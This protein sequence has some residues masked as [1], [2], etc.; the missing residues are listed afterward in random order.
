MHSD[1]SATLHNVSTPRA[2]ARALCRNGCEEL[3]V[4]ATVG[5]HDEKIGAFQ[6]AAGLIADRRAGI[7]S[8]RVFGLRD[9]SQKSMEV[10]GG[11]FG[12][13][14]WPL[15]WLDEGWQNDPPLAGIEVQAVRGSR[16]RPVRLDD[17]VVGSV[18]E[19]QHAV[20]CKLGGLLPA[21]VSLPRPRQA[22]EVFEKMIDGLEH[23]GMRFEHM[24]RTWLW[25]DDILDWYDGFNEVRTSFFEEHGLFDHFPPASTGIGAHNAAG[26]AVAAE[27]IA[28]R[29]KGTEAKVAPVG[30]PLQ[31]P[32]PAYG[33][34]FSRAA[35]MSTPEYRRLFVSG[36][37][38]I[39]ADGKTMYRADPEQ[40]I[41]RTMEVVGAILDSRGMAWSD[42]TRS[43]AYFRNA[44][45]APAFPAYCA[46]HDLE[47][48]PNIIVNSTICRED[49]LFELELDAVRPGR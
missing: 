36:T 19:D 23:A 45:A 40:Q 29:P 14:R 10:L 3:F 9:S 27:L 6:A 26:A 13:V 8:L 4:T 24:V 7:V 22:R 43:I 1:D 28:M 32:A 48:M 41:G 2:E 42:V 30:S 18:Y 39:S 21:D 16:V 15:T 44:A 20:Y 17:R 5:S 25:I 49:L 11:V 47:N 33:S 31:C 38:S 37:A 46:A 35:E 12:P 34:S